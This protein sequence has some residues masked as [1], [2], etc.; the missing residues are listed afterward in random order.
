MIRSVRTVLNMLALKQAYS[1]KTLLS[2]IADVGFIVSSREITLLKFTEIVEKPWTPND[3]LLIKPSND[4]I[5]VLLPDD[6]SFSRSRF[7]QIKYL[8]NVF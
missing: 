1:D 3:L 6:K 5:S 7:C 4:T 8:A 2:L